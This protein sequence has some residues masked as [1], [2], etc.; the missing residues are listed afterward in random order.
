MYKLF[1]DDP[2]SIR[3]RILFFEMTGYK[4]LNFYGVDVRFP[5]DPYPAQEEYI[6]KCVEALVKR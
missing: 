4:T 1:S 6:K 2:V 5:Y 3:R